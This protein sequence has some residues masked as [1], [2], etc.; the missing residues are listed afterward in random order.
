MITKASWILFITL[1]I[2][3]G[4]YPIVYFIGDREFGLLSS[5]SD[6]L[7]LNIFWNIG[8]YTH[9]IFGGIALL[10]G[11]AQFSSKFRNKNIS[12]HI[13]IGKIYIISALLSS[14]A[15]IGIGFYATGGIITAI[16]FISLGII[17]FG[18]T[19]LSFL[20]IRKKQIVRHQKLMIYSYAACIAAVTLRIWLPLLIMTF[21]DF[22]VS[23]TIVSWLCWVPNMAVA[24]FITNRVS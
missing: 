23:Y 12:L 8:F 7:L 14:I 2:T 4:L 19:L 17:W 6:E 18:T 5:K 24:Y 3:I 16:G 9:I 15:G 20:A 21:N 1:C 11:W 22:I 13:S 10:I